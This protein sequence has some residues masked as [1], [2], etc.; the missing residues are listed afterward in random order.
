MNARI[1]RIEAF[2]LRLPLP[3]P[4]RLGEMLIPYREYSMV[5]VYDQD[6]RFGSA[7]ALSRNAP[8]AQVVQQTITPFWENQ[9]LEAHQTF[10]TH[11][12]RANVCLGTNGIFWRALSLADCALFDLLAQRA[13]QPLAVYLGGTPRRI[14]TA[15]VGGYPS[16]DESAASLADWAQVTAARQPA[17]IKIASTSDYAQDTQRLRAIRSAIPDGP[18]LAI[19]LYW[20][21]PDAATLLRDASDWSAL[22][23]AWIE[24][25]FP[26]DDFENIA[27]LA[28]A[29]DYPVAVGDEQSGIRHFRHL[30]DLGRIDIV[31]MDPT[32]VGGVRVFLE[33]ARQAAARGLEVSCHGSPFLNS[34][35]A[36]AIPNGRWIEYLPNDLEPINALFTEDLPWER[37]GFRAVSASGAGY[38]WDEAALT[39]ARLN[40]DR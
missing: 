15:L 33:I 21:A 12:V 38:P 10:Y 5:R 26:F 27:S 2:E 14:D 28:D 32:V 18:L 4:L 40:Q 20:R 13:E 23:M 3:R 30:M 39:S 22:G 17:V 24:D 16:P 31:R 34:Q 1:A 25:P 9:P 7:Y 36:S 37:G 29:L 6:G 8:I 19:D 35:L 11:T